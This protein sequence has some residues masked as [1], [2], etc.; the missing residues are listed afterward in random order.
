[1]NNVNLIDVASVVYLFDYVKR[2]EYSEWERA[3]DSLTMRDSVASMLSDALIVAPLMHVVHLHQEAAATVAATSSASATYFYHYQGAMQQQQILP[4][5][6]SSASSSSSS[7]LASPDAI[8]AD[9]EHHHV[10]SLL[11]NVR[12][13]FKHMTHA[14]RSFHSHLDW[15]WKTKEDDARQ[16]KSARNPT[17]GGISSSIA[18]Y[19]W[20]FQ[21]QDLKSV[22]K[23]SKR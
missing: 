21:H 11:L 23:V 20:H 12:W 16:N 10:R 13:A 17:L 1:M 4:I 6:P 8:A 22:V 5:D 9:T 15:E 18:L 14:F 3:Q 7:S 2:N 19:Y